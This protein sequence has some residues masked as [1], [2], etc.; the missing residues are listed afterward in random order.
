MPTEFWH[1]VFGTLVVKYP[2][3]KGLKFELSGS[4]Y[5]G[6]ELEVTI[7]KSKVKKL[8]STKKAKENG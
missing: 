4:K 7:K 2:K 5:Y 1:D 8:P 3:G 6:Y